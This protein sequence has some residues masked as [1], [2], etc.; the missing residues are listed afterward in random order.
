MMG[1]SSGGPGLPMARSGN[2]MTLPTSFKSSHM[3]SGLGWPAID[4]MA[5]AGTVVG[6]P[7]AGVVEYW[8]PEGAQGGGSILFDPIAPG[9]D[10]WLG[11]LDAGVPAG[12]RLKRGQRLA[13]VSSRHAAPHVHEARD[14]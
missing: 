13:L 10:Y 12:T 14:Y 7:E 5:E 11:H 1:R 8:H 3:T 2:V 4:I 9:P 6:A